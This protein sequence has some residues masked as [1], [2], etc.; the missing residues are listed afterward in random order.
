MHVR[1]GNEE[2]ERSREKDRKKEARKKDADDDKS[3]KK[4]EV[5]GGEDDDFSSPEAEEKHSQQQQRAEEGALIP[6]DW[7]E[8]VIVIRTPVKVKSFAFANGTFSAPKVTKTKTRKYV[9]LVFALQN[10]SLGLYRCRQRMPSKE[11][12]VDKVYSNRKNLTLQG[13]RAGIRAVAMSHDNQLV[14]TTSAHTTK[15]WRASSNSFE[16]IRTWCSRT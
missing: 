6:S 13:H 3:E 8:S 1:K 11:I 7:F 9:G 2:R 16:C 14:V 5:L 12:S 10:N 15:V 4:I